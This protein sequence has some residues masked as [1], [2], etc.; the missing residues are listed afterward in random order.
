MELIAPAAAAG[1]VATAPAGVT[2]G[3]AASA[4]EG[5]APAAPRGSATLRP[6][7]ARHAGA[8]L[9]PALPG[10]AAV[11]IALWLASDQAG[12][13]IT[14]WAPAG[15]L[16][17]A[18]LAVTAAAVPPSLRA[19]PWSVR[20]AVVALAGVTAWSFAS[21]AWAGD[22]G[23]A[24]TGAAR[25]LAYLAVFALLALWPQRPETAAVV[26]GTWTLGLAALALVTLVRLGLADDPLRWFIYDR[27]AHPAEYPNATAAQWL[28]G[29]WPAVLLAAAPRV[30]WALRG[31]FA[32]AAVVLAGL[33]LLSQ[34]RGAMLAVPLTALLVLA[35]VPGRLRTAGILAVV[36]A[37]VGAVAPV[38]LDVG[39]A[40]NGDAQPVEAVR[41]AVRALLAAAAAAGVAIAAGGAAWARRAPGPATVA[42]VRR[43]G[44]AATALAA[45]AIVA[46][47]LAAVGDP[48][49]RAG[50]AWD[51]FNQGYGEVQGTR[52]TSGLGSNR[53][54]FYRVA[55]DLFA[56][57]PVAGIGVEGFRPEYLVH[58]RSA[59]TPAYAHSLPLRTL[60][61]TG[62][63][64]TLLL[65]AALAAAVVAAAAAMRRRDDPTLAA[66][67]AGGALGAA[68]YWLVHGAADWFFEI[69]GLGFAAFLLLGLACGLAPRRATVARGG[70]GAVPAGGAGAVT[71]G[72]APEGRGRRRRA[73]AAVAASVV[74]VAA[75]AALALPWLAE[76]DVLA[77]GDAFAGRPADAFAH[78]RRAADLQ[79]LSDRPALV[80]GSI[81]VRHG[82]LALADREFAVALERNPRG[83]YATLMRGAIASE[84]GDRAQAQAL[85]RRAVAL[86]PRD[87]IARTALAAVRRGDAVDVARL[88]ATIHAAGAFD[89]GRRDASP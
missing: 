53:S 85:L 35:V 77:A 56:E 7:S 13:P 48:V 82:D 21:I 49:A 28:M 14:R 40:I 55:L 38:L 80:G 36:A 24:W 71:P 89:D 20:L 3:S 62:L 66:A 65:A 22:Q 8:W 41:D 17:L 31:A 42:R 11:A 16:A 68:A 59:E 67:A 58:G 2:D 33:A 32:G 57:H 39:T 64:G 6:R 37:A 27:L 29:A 54:D 5:P 60:A 25:T 30:H 34:S 75:G 50:N 23:A 18:L 70:E 10:L 12:Y 72:G 46:G 84:R 44:T 73:L 9:A 81:A 69:G 4:A 1:G 19:A 63:A 87:R 26:A 78:L 86:A 74:A 47:G 88:S 76:R 79:P 61:E 52:L 51:S 43:A 83:Q 45:V 15:L